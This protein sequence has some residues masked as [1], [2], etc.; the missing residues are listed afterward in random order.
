M[1]NISVKYQLIIF[2][3][4][5]ALFLS[6]LD[7]DV[8]FLIATAVSVVVALATEAVI[9]YIKKR[10]LFFSDSAVITGLIIGF[11][12]YD[13]NAWWLFCAAASMA[14]VF[15]H[16]VRVNGKHIF[17]PAAFG[18]LSVILLF[19]ADT[20]WKGTYYWQI[21]IPVGIY[22]AYKVRKLDLIIS[23]A[24]VSFLLF[25]AQALIYQRPITEVAGYFSFF[26]IFIMMIEPKTTPIKKKAKI[27]FG[28]LVAVL[29]FSLTNLGARFD[30]ELASLLTANAAVLLLNNVK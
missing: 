23:Y 11:V 28:V 16:L 9:A 26:Y 24:L 6:V 12:L 27:I 20:Q 7:R 1:K 21:L 8:L 17:N 2:L 10:K 15:K 22:F 25:G 14:I 3:T 5:F 13:R 4:A 19:G 18:V 29:I 30:V